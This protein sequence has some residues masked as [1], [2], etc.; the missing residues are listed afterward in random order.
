MQLMKTRLTLL[1]L[2]ILLC[3]TFAT[4]AVFG[5]TT[6]IWT[7]L[8]MTSPDGNDIGYSTNWSGPAGPGLNRPV[9][10][11]TLEWNGTVPGPM[12]LYHDIANIDNNG[13]IG[14]IGGGPGSSG[15]SF[16]INASQTSPVTISTRTAPTSAG[17]GFNAFT[18]DFGAGQLTLGDTSQNALLLTA[19]P[20]GATHDWINNSTNPVIICPNVAWQ[21]GG[22]AAFTVILDGT[23]DYGITNRLGSAESGLITWVISTSGTVTWN[24]YSTPLG[25]LFGPIT[26]I[27]NGGTLIL[28][29]NIFGNLTVSNGTFAACPPGTVGTVTVSNK[30]TISSG[31]IVTTVNKSLA[32]SNGIYQVSSNFTASGGTLRLV[33][34]GPNFV[35]GD[36]FVIFANPDGTPKAVT[37]G[38]NIAVTAPGVTTWINNL[39]TD[40]S[41]TVQTVT[42][43]PMAFTAATQSG[44]NVILSWPAVWTGVHLQSQTNTLA[45][46]LGTN[47]VT[48]PGSAAANSYSAPLVKT[49]GPVFFRLAP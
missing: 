6:L 40:G 15:T 38:E 37:G 36:K 41:V 49:N 12:V 35:A 10:G 19:R 22:G 5:Q 32:Q 21:N 33:N 1:K 47:W 13:G 25:V 23:G 7:N 18:V 17:M 42:A 2:T 34:Y 48:I 44:G 8:L 24:S 31:T 43:T 26:V 20:A 11:T 9:S 30:L 14:P 39:K 28:K 4:T 3:F 29:T 46:G 16:Y 27:L 45:I